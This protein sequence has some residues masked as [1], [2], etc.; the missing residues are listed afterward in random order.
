MP[1][2]TKLDKGS[3]VSVFLQSEDSVLSGMDTFALFTPG[4][5]TRYI[6][7]HKLS[8]SFVIFNFVEKSQRKGI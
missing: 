6:C 1:R 7:G 2:F 8:T 5:D 3:A 4:K